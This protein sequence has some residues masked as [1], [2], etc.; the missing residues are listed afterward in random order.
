MRRPA[1]QL[2]VDL[3]DRVVLRMNAEMLV[4]RMQVAMIL[5]EPFV[6]LHANEKTDSQDCELTETQKQKHDFLL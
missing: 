6:A 3:C 2:P 1:L 5:P 4:D